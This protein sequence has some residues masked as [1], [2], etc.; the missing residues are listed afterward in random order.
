MVNRLAIQTMDQ[1]YRIFLVFYLLTNF[2]T[3]PEVVL[4]K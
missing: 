4:K 1:I 3:W 2:E